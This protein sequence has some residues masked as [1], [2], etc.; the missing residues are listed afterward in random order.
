MECLD[1]YDPTTTTTTMCAA[2]TAGGEL[3]VADD[4]EAWMNF[5]GDGSTDN[6]CLRGTLQ[7]AT[8]R[9]VVR[10]PQRL[11]RPRALPWGTHVVGK[12][13]YGDPGLAEVC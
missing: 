10:Q 12:L 9:R 4:L 5:G 1:G 8:L 13:P 2:A 3:D 7:R 6:Y 11:L